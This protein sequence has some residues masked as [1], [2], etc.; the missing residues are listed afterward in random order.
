M[1]ISQ[2]AAIILATAIGRQ[3]PVVLKTRT[4]Q[5]NDWE[6]RRRNSCHFVV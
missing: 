5:V 4:A 2:P 3:R 1:K 6:Q